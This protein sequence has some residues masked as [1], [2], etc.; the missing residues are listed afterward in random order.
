MKN[1]KLFSVLLIAMA[2]ALSA[3]MPAA[4]ATTDL[5]VDYIKI[6][7]EE[8]DSAASGITLEVTRG[9][10][11]DIR[12]R[13]SAPNI[14]VENVQVSA[15]LYGYQYSQY[16][17]EKVY[18]ISN[19]F[20]LDAGNTRNVDLNLEIPVRMDDED[21]VLRLLVADRTGTAY[22]REYNLDVEGTD[23][24]EAIMIKDAYLSPSNTVMAGR[25]LSSL[26]KIENIGQRDL[27]DITLLVSVPELGIRDTETLD[28]LEANE[29][30]TFEKII[31][32]FPKDAQ[33]GNYLVEYTVKFDEF[34]SVTETDFVTVNPCENVACGAA[35]PT[36][37]SEGQTVVQVPN[38]QLVTAG[39]GEAAFP[40]VLNNLGDGAEAYMVQV[41]GVDAWGTARVDPGAQIIVP[42]RSSATAFVYVAANEEAS[43][44][45]KY[46]KVSISTA[47]GE[48]KEVPLSAQVVAGAEAE[49]SSLQRTLEVA[50]IILIVVL[51]LIGLIV[52]FSKLRGGNNGDD[53]AKTYY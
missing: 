12:V 51:I 43:E 19:T 41:A 50:L 30:E 48:M 25:A 21:M 17:N 4:S 23:R 5:N 44:G 11:L 20:D 39:A 35:A 1:T 29:V 52:G 46:F 47:D 40:I 14:S 22:I 6:D 26:V 24:S 9:E 7:G 13:V 42:A 10:T 34:E 49:G 3:F 27:D 33:P 8:L 28:E 32:R 36:D 2:L 31:L 53:D 45:E 18:D 15:G 38:A 16:E 37:S